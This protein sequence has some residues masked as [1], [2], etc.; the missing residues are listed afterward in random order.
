MQSRM[1]DGRNTPNESHGSLCGPRKKPTLKLSMNLKC[2]NT[3][4]LYKAEFTFSP[5][6]KDRLL[7]FLCLLLNTLNLYFEQ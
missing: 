4:P 1:P 7:G 5:E 3:Q 2:K 6:V